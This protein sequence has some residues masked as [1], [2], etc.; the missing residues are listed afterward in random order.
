MRKSDLIAPIMINFIK[1]LKSKDHLY[2]FGNFN[3]WDDALSEASKYGKAYEGDNIIDKVAASTNMVREGK[4]L[5]EQDGVL[6]YEENYVHEL[7]SSL[8]YIYIESNKL[9]ICDLGGALGSTFFRYKSKL[10]KANIDWNIVEQKHYIDRGKKEVPEIDFYYTVEEC[11]SNKPSVN[12]VLLLS[13]LPYLDD[14]YGMLER[15]FALSQIKYIVIDETV[16]NV[17]DEESAH[18]VLQHV[19]ANYYEAIYPSHIFNRNDFVNF[20]EKA[21][22]K[23]IFEWKYPQ[24]AIPIRTTFGY[25]NNIDRGFLFKRDC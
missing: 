5:Y 18:I 11:M 17:N 20:I 3:T 7:L 2:Y 6:Y 25:R 15:I 16:F 21:N 4:A 14:P 23:K 12:T 19:P 24:G 10:P 8:Y 9:D 22:F 1:R 13:V